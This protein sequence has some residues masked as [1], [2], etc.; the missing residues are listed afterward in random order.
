M[1]AS[2]SGLRL[3]DLGARALKREILR[4]VASVTRAAWSPDGRRLAIA[5]T[6]A[7]VRLWDVQSDRLE[8]RS[9]WARTRSGASRSVPTE[10]A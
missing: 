8:A 3:W 5:S 10:S 9:P 7:R 2:K 4:D 1:T 6:D